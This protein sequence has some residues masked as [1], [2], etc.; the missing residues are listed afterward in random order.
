MTCQSPV[1]KLIVYKYNIADSD[2]IVLDLTRP[3]H[4]DPGDRGIVRGLP[5]AKSPVP[6]ASTTDFVC[7]S[8]GSVRNSPAPNP[9]QKSLNLS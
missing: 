1:I 7:A 4:K 8:F 9:Y 2:V 6:W 5:V 3:A